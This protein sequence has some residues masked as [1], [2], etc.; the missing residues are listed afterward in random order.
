MVCS[1]SRETASTQ[2]DLI[3]SRMTDHSEDPCKLGDRKFDGLFQQGTFPL[4]L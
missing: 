3:T 1:L 4:Y 2:P